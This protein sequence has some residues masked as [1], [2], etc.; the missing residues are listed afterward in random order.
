MKFR[1]LLTCLS[2]LAV[3]SPLFASVSVTSPANGAT[4]GSP[5]LY[6][7]T[8]S[9]PGCKAGV[10][11]V[12]VYVNNTLVF[13]ENGSNLKTEISLNS[14]TYQTAVQEWDYCGGSTL[15]PINIK[16]AASG[17]GVVVSSPA[18]GSTVASPARF[19][20]TATAPSCAK[21]VA[22]MGVYVDNK[23]ADIVNGTSL[24]ILV[25]LTSGVHQT[26]VQQWDYCGGST[27]TPVTVN[28]GTQSGQSCPSL[29]VV[30]GPPQ[31][32][33]PAPPIPA[34]TPGSTAA[35]SICV[36]NPIANANVTSPMTLTS[37]A[38]MLQAPLA[39]QRVYIDGVADYFT[40]YNQFTGSFWMT[41]GRHRLDVV[42]TDVNGK[43][44]SNTFFVNVTGT[45][46]Q[47]V[48]NLQNIPNWEPCAA[49]YGPTTSR[50]GQICAAGFGD[51]NST[52]TENVSN[53]SLSG[54]SAHFTM[55]GPTPYSNELYTVNLGG[56]DSPTHFIYDFYMMID[57]PTASQALEF[58]VNQTINNTR[59]TWGTECNFNGNYPNVGEWDIWNG[60]PNT[61]WTKT[62]V[63]CAP[64]AANQWQHIIWTFERVGQQVHYISLSVN[65]NVYPLNIYLP[66][67]Q[68]WSMGQINAAFQ[69][70]GNATQ[71]PYNVWLDKVSLT[72]Y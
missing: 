20:A 17:S 46:Y 5:A 14:G 1:N 41:T 51:T 23:I 34:V 61:G 71:E 48:T 25:P 68:N 7:A 50:A 35:G 9:A 10:A 60:A 22:A 6:V 49:L 26:A 70:D 29:P 58:D 2:L 11:A 39:Y 62:S 54:S 64:F 21:G 42:A 65:G 12:G 18:N 63:P 33:P 52:M 28:V 32:F 59:W 27:F 38:N 67:Q 8:A 30:A 13:K 3:S 44:A 19:T 55:G 69:M 24:N 53:P 4:V 31:P 37:V 15:T 43:I 45:A 56:G 57:K 66:A 36:S 47:T 16:V 40:F 72:V